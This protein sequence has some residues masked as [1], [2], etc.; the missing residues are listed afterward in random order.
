PPALPPPLADTA[1]LLRGHARQDGRLGQPAGD[2][3]HA[4]PPGD[5]RG[6]RPARMERALPAGARIPPRALDALPLLARGHD[7][8]LELRRLA[9]ALLRRLPPDGAEHAP[10]ARHARPQ[11]TS[12]S[13]TATASSSASCPACCSAGGRFAPLP[14]G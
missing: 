7:V 1:E 14:S 2:R 3:A 4:D 12:C 9:P 13:L 11:G 5:A 10:A 8:D 6:P